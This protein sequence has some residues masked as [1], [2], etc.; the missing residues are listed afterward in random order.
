MAFFEKYQKPDIDLIA[1]TNGPG[2]EPCLWVGVNF[3]KALAYYWEIP[4]ITVN[5]IKAHIFVNELNKKPLTKKDF[6][7]VCLIVSG[8]H[9]KLFLM[10]DFGKYKILGET[11]DDAAGECFDKTARILG[12]G[13]PGGPIIANLPEKNK[14]VLLFL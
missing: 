7:A 5:H 8:G 14:T 2:L 10:T 6:P 9:T 13:Y 4:I 3:A 12:F 1:I 11:R